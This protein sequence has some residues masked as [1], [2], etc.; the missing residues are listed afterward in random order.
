MLST[1]E[2]NLLRLLQRCE[3]QWRAHGAADNWSEPE[4]DRYT[5]QI[6]Y[7]QELSS[8]IPPENRSEYFPRIDQLVHQQPS[9]KSS[10]SDTLPQSKK[11]ILTTLEQYQQPL[12]PDW[13]KELSKEKE[14]GT[15][16]QTQTQSQAKAHVQASATTPEVRQRRKRSPS[17][18]QETGNVESVLQH[19]RQIHDELTTDLGRMARQLK[20]NS[21]SFGDTLGK[22][23]KV[24]QQ[25]QDVVSGNLDRLHKER[26]RLDAHYSKS[27]G[28][29]FMTMGVVLFVCIMFVLVFFTIKF[30]PKA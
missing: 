23:D 2:T 21:Q 15:P 4:R 6:E 30:L 20:M 11:Q 7:L 19:H 24:L 22:D 17:R 16:L 1:D 8:R 3:E 5:T 9:R 29:S 26:R 28:T 13:L 14:Q 18:S 25:A 27:W 12:E 10:L